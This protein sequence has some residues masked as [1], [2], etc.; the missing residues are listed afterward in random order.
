MFQHLTLN[1]ILIILFGV[2]LIFLGVW[3]GLSFG[4]RGQGVGLFFIGLGT[5]ILGFTNGFTDFSPQGRFLYRVAIISF[6]IGMPVSL[7]Y[8][9]LFIS[10]G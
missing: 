1:S 9:F 7:Y 8:L 5:A 3:S 2:I 10:K 6:L 4:G